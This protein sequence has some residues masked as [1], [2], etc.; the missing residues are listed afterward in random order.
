M[1]DL[2]CMY[3]LGECKFQ[4]LMSPSFFNP[5]VSW[6]AGILYADSFD[7]ILT[8]NTNKS[9]TSTVGSNFV[10]FWRMKAQTRVWFVDFQQKKSDVSGFSINPTAKARGIY[11]LKFF[12]L[13]AD[14]SQYK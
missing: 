1:E 4:S 6:G 13:I 10:D 14:Y 9:V 7:V 2:Y 12:F 8:K 5:D 11:I 3:V